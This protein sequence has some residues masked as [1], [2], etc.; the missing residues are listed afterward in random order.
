MIPYVTYQNTKMTTD[1]PKEFNSQFY[2]K[3]K[4]SKILETLANLS[5][6][7]PLFID[8]V[9]Q[10][11]ALLIASKSGKDGCDSDERM[12]EIV[13]L[14]E[15]LTNKVMLCIRDPT[16]NRFDIIEPLVDMC[17]WSS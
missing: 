10:Y 14:Q 1:I 4:N 2:E 9:K 13:Q 6:D 5:Y 3:K 15:T 17:K 8:E 7:D 16:I 12:D 11:N